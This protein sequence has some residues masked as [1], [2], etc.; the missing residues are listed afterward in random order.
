MLFKKS[1]ISTLFFLI[2]T[3]VLAVLL[4]INRS[5]KEEGRSYDSSTVFSK[6][7]HI[8]ELSTVKYN[9]TGVIGYKDAKKFFNINIPLTEK[10]FL[11]KYNGYLKAG[12]DFDKILVDVD[13][14]KVRVSIPRARI[15]DIVIDENSITVYNESDNAFNPIKISDYNQALAKEKETMRRDAIKQGILKDANQHAELAIK[16]IL[17]E[18]GFNDVDITMELVIP[19]IH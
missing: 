2:T 11:V 12:V 9:Y 18:M 15:F 3:V 7:S 8:Q 19:E 4:L 13:D 14:D 6:I 16:S 10:F 17:K 5:G 1:N